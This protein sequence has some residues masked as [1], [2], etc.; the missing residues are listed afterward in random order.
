VK[1]S[2]PC[3]IKICSAVVKVLPLDS[4]MDRKLWRRL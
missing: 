3:F 4:Q 2:T 1:L